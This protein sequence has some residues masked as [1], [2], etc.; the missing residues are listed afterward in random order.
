MASVDQIRAAILDAQSLGVT[1][2]QLLVLAR[3]ALAEA[4]TQGVPVIQLS[5]PTGVSQTY[6][7]DTLRGIIEQAER[8]AQAENGG[9]IHFAQAG[10]P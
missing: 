2:S 3:R 10:L 8:R 9:G 7:L 5:L 1:W 6:G 4:L